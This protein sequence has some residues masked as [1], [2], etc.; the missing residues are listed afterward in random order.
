M[1]RFIVM[2]LFSM[3][4]WTAHA[5]PGHGESLLEE[6][7]HTLFA[8]DHLPVSIVIGMGIVTVA[9]YVGAELAVRHTK[10][11]LA[12]L[13]RASSMLTA[14]VGMGAAFRLGV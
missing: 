2:G 11:R 3:L 7:F 8:A 4:S 10:G 9:L 6:V 1:Q 13:L 14:L 12:W 5:H